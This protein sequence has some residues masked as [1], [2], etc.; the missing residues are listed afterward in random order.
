MSLQNKSP[1]V[2]WFSRHV[3][4]NQRAA[5]LSCWSMLRSLKDIN[6]PPTSHWPGAVT[7]T[8]AMAVLKRRTWPTPVELRLVVVVTTLC[9]ASWVTWCHELWM[10]YDRKTQPWQVTIAFFRWFF[11]LEPPF[12]GDLHCH[13]W[14]PEDSRS[15]IEALWLMF[16]GFICVYNGI[17][18]GLWWGYSGVKA[19]L[20]WL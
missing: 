7:T 1:P 20:V 14:L 9:G 12:I 16:S 2:Q 6:Q 3:W 15:N 8:T 19:Q 4:W 10:F 5:H 13:V 18:G 17:V 11:H